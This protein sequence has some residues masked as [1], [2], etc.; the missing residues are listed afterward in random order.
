MAPQSKRGRCS[1]T[2]VSAESTTLKEIQ[3][4]KKL[5]A[6]AALL[7]S[8]AAQASAMDQPPANPDDY[9]CRFEDLPPMRFQRRDPIHYILLIGDALPVKLNVG[10][11]YATA[12]FQGQELIF[13]EDGDS[14]RIADVLFKGECK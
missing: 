11:A 3:E 14:V 4:L 10:S 2:Y 7:L 6:A 12:E 9:T 5:L 13:W 1:A 8:F